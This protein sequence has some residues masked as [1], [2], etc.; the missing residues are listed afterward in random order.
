[1]I[2]LESS[3]VIN[4]PVEEVFAFVT[5]ME[6]RPQWMSG[7]EELRWTSDGPPRVGS[8]FRTVRRA[9]G[10]RMESDSVL[11]A[12]EPNSKYSYKTTGGPFSMEVT[13]TFE[14]VQDGTEYRVFAQGGLSGVFTIVAPV[15]GRMVKR[16]LETD[17]SN[18]KDLLERGPESDATGQ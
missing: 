6:R 11:T 4:R 5:D 12:Y 15:L 7:V 16:D 17:L 9:M 2:N 1:M 14:A 18:L 13:A 8:T 10:R 3:T